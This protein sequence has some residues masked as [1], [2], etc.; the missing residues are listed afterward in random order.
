MTHHD[1]TWYNDPHH[2]EL[3]ITILFM[4]TLIIM[5]DSHHDDSQ[6]NN[7]RHDD[8]QHNGTDHAELSIASH[9]ADTQHADTHHDEAQYVE[10]H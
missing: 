2:A 9:Y 1:D 10:Y 8:T 6:H 3:G 7:T 5:N 4:L